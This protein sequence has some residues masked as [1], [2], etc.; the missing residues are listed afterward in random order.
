M[1]E[2]KKREEGTSMAIMR[3]ELPSGVVP[4]RNPEPE[5]HHG[6]FWSHTLV[7]AAIAAVAVVVAYQVL[8]GALFWARVKVD[9]FRYGY[10][11]SYQIDGYVGYDES[12]GQPTHFIALN[13]H[14]QVM[15]MIV[16]GDDP[17]H[18]TTLKGPYLYG[19]DQEYTPVTL[20]L[21]GVNSDG[22]PDLVLNVAQQQVVWVDQP[23]QARFRPLLPAE[24][25]AAMRALGAAQ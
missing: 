15:V 10:P 4:M 19:A 2:A 18:V 7:S 25:A 1:G 20:R 17:T 22:Y 9:D 21:I 23:R 3:R 16:A 14:R 11:R 6:G 13:L 24:H 8:A 12:N 5:R